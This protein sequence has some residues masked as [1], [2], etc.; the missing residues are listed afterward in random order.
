MF[1]I[2]FRLDH[3]GAGHTES[4]A[5]NLEADL[6]RGLRDKEFTLHY[7]P[8]C[9][10]LNGRVAG[11]EALLRW[12]NSRGGPIAPNTY[13]PVAERT[14]QIHDLGRWALNTACEQLAKWDRE[15]LV[16]PFV[17][18]NV[19]PAQMLDAAFIGYVDDAISAAGIEGTRVVLEITEGLRIHDIGHTS[20][21][22][23]ALRGRG[24]GLAVDDFG[25]GHSSL[26]YLQA[27]PLS[28][29]KIDRSFVANLP[30]SR[31]DS[32]IVRALV[33][34]ARELDLGL[35]AEGVENE[36]QRMRL[37]ELGCEYVQGWLTCKPISAEELARRFAARTLWIEDVPNLLTVAH[38]RFLKGH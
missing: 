21:V 1:E 29:I 17:S 3:S 15:N 7:Q 12:R 4:T 8:I 36:A 34:L 31:A 18:V 20:R 23:D 32:A 2:D 28:K 38:D 10:I 24:I 26:I 35:V 30:S 14:G 37:A 16:L 9:S 33:G 27:L 11:V 5:I 6:A 25:T 19:S 22:F 13:I